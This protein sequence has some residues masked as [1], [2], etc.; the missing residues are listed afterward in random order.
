MKNKAESHS[1]FRG[2]KADDTLT[3]V[4]VAAI[5]DSLEKKNNLKVLNLNFSR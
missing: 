3:D 5:I 2:G 4:G 1:C